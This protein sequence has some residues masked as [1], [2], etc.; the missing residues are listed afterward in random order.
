MALVKVAQFVVSWMLR[1]WSIFIDWEDTSLVT[2]GLLTFDVGALHER[3][4]R[5]EHYSAVGLRRVERLSEGML[6]QAA[7][8]VA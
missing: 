7:E 4:V 1:L 8:I 5:R 2:Q 3:S 6:V